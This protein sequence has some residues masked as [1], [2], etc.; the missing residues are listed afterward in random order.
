LRQAAEL[1]DQ[2]GAN[3]FRINAYRR[4]ADTLT[5]LP[6]D[7]GEIIDQKGYEGLT[8]LPNVGRGI[9]SAIWEMAATGNWG[10]LKRLRGGGDPI[11]LLTTVPGVGPRLAKAIHEELHIDTL[12]ALETAAYDGRL[13]TLRAFGPRRLAA[14]RAT[15][16]SML[17]RTRRT[18]AVEAPAAPPSVSDL[19]SVDADYREKAARSALP[20]ITPKRFNPDGSHRLPVLHAT[21]GQWHFTAIFS[22]TARAHE[23]GRTRDWVVVYFYDNHHEEGQSTVVT[24]TRG[25]LNGKRV[26]RGREAECRDYYDEGR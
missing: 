1:L 23:L 19:L 26:V 10:L 13:S 18:A 17:G 4:A 9:A 22:N 5:K 20:V 12:E 24:E 14:L 6:E 3:P 25:P 15:L 21:L 11:G 2:Q 7:I 16:S 8:A